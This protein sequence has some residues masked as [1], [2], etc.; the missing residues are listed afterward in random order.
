MEYLITIKITLLVTLFLLSGFFSCSEAALFSL[1]PLHLHKMKEEH[2]PFHSYVNRLLEQPRRLLITILVSNESVNI[3]ISVIVASLC[4]RYF[5][6]DGHWVAVAVTTP[7]LLIFAEAIPKTLAVIR[8]ILFSSLVSPL[9]ILLSGIERPIVWIL[10]SVSGFVVSVLSGEK[11]PDKK[12]FT[13]D[14]FKTLVDVYQKEGGL[15]EAQ[16]DLIHSVFALADK[17]IS[18]I[19]IPR[20]EMF[21]LPISLGMSEM[22]A[23]I[24][25]ARHTRIP[26][27]GTDRDD[28]L[29]ILFAR[30]L[31]AG[32]SGKGI[33]IDKLLRKPWFVPEVKSAASLLREFKSRRIQI[34]IV[35]DEYGGV[36]GMVTLEDVLESLFEDIYE[37]YGL[38]DNLWQKVDERTFLVSGR[39]PAEDLNALIGISIPEDEFDTVGGFAFHLFGKLPAKGEE[40]AFEDYTFRVERMGRA[41]ILSL[42]LERREEK[43][44]E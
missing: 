40:V 25:K 27:Y 7:A 17:P 19:M 26:I 2:V 16:R 13:E 34:A 35:V 38:K 39:M 9:L 23:E 11:P 10:E 5:G 6:E 30:D 33:S 21:C 8:P 37:D 24:I 44:E 18:E 1:T 31:I 28:I 12:T 4:I 32:I 41:R 14:E 15:E 43:S 22:E 29:G 42:R 3:T 36:S 20:V